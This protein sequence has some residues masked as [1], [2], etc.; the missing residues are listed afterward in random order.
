VIMYQTTHTTKFPRGFQ[1]NS[2]TSYREII[3]ISI[4]SPATHRML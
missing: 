1:T 2:P 4:Q 3:Y